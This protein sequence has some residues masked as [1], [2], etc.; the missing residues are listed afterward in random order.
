MREPAKSELDSEERISNQIEY[1]RNA[2]TL[3]KRAVTILEN[4][5]AFAQRNNSSVACI[6]LDVDHFWSGVKLLGPGFGQL[7]LSRADEFI[8]RT[9]RPGQAASFGRD[10]FL[11]VAEDVDV[12]KALL[13]A[14]GVR[15]QLVE[16]LTSFSLDQGLPASANI[17]CSS[18]IA[19]YPD[20]ATN[21]AELVSKALESL[22]CAK[23]GGRNQTKMPASGNMILKSNYYS[24]IQLERLRRLAQSAGR[25]EASILREALDVYLREYDI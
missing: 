18:G 21:A 24:S 15:S 7:L 1:Y 2:P 13:L 25:T 9:A 20:H 6:L 8:R 23:Q 22:Y 3:N 12:E 17:G 4:R 10:E 19:I 5:I 14:E 16:L 11:V